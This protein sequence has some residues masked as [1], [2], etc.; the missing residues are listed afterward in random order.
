MESQ[1]ANLATDGV[2]GRDDNSLGGI[3]DDNLDTCSSLKGSDIT[4]LATDDTTLNLVV[5][6]VEHA[7][8]ILD[9]SLGSHTLDGL[10]DNLLGLLV[11]IEL[12][13]VYNLVD[14]A[15]GIKFGLVLQAVYQSFLGFLGAQTRELFEL[16]TLL[17]LH[18][19]KFLLL[20]E[21]QLLLVVYT[22]LK[23]GEF[24]L[25]SAYLVLTLVE[26]YLALL[27]PVLVLQNLLVALLHLLLQLTLLVEEFLLDFKQFL[28]LYHFGFL[29]GCR[30]HFIVFSLNDITE[31]HITSQYSHDESYGHYNQCNYHF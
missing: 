17:L 11:G 13:L 9:S 14:I 18:L 19:L 4:T 25:L 28:L 27:E 5:I 10:D 26:R 31:N 24:L 15:G 29:R 23:L 6:N 1:T 16:G 7:H 3:V 8:R 22:L 21:H 2:K 20:Y 12:G 30:Y